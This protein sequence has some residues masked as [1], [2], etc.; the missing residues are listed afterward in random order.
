MIWGASNWFSNHFRVPTNLFCLKG[1]HRPK[2]VEKHCSRGIIDNSPLL[3]NNF[4][5]LADEM[6]WNLSKLIFVSLFANQCQI[7]CIEW[8]W[9]FTVA[10]T[11]Q[12]SPAARLR[13]YSTRVP[14][15]P[16]SIYEEK[17]IK[18]ILLYV[19]VVVHDILNK[20]RSH[21]QILKLQYRQF[22]KGLF[23]AV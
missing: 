14:R 16:T 20:I 6:F 21:I 19:H 8:K 5:R 15:C 9:V 13:A 2:K 22:S 3:K 23:F 10:V 17:I 18:S 12:C 7:T 1:C 11:K 4:H